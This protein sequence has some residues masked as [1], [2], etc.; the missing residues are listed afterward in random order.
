MLTYDVYQELGG[1]CDLTAFTRNI[2]RAIG[3]VR[4]ATYDRVS[5]MK[6][7]PREVQVCLRDIVEYLNENSINGNVTSRSQSVGGVS[8]SV[9]YA[10]K[11]E[12]DA[13]INTIICDHLAYICDDCGTP[14]L[15]R[16]C[17]R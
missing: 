12:I 9:S 14:L 7:V 10:T 5:A 15:Y 13:G 2:D 6:S 16:G 8:E 4:N 11:E 3:I 1:V 17:M